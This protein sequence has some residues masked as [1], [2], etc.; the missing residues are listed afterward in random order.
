MNTNP[1]NET[2]FEGQCAQLDAELNHPWW[3][4]KEVE[5]IL[6][7][8]ATGLGHET[9]VALTMAFADQA[10]LTVEQQDLLE[11]MLFSSPTA[12]RHHNEIGGAP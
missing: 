3:A 6:D 5:A 12:T 7:R 11:D 9:L 2:A 4:T 8:V 1:D 10:G